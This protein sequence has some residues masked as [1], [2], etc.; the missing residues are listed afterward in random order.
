MCLAMFEV[1]CLEVTVKCRYIELILNSRV[2]RKTE[3]KKR[4]FLLFCFIDPDDVREIN[5]V[6]ERFDFVRSR[7]DSSRFWS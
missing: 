3:R 1:H 2:A 6:K 4:N 7:N 5:E